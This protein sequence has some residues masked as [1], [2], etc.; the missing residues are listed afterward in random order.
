MNTEIICPK[1]RELMSV[2]Y[3]V[4]GSSHE[5]EESFSY[6]ECDNC[7]FEKHD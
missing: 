7:G 4:I 3:D 1:C 2:R 6:L 5:T